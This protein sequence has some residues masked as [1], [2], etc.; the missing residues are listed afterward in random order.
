MKIQ[1]ED[2]IYLALGL[3]RHAMRNQHFSE[4]EQ[5]MVLVSASELTR[6]VL[7]HA[8][9]NGVFRCECIDGGVRLTVM[10]MGP[11]IPHVDDILSSV[12]AVASKRGLGLG[13]AGV[14]RLM[15]DMRIE[16]SAEGTTVIATKWERRSRG[17]HTEPIGRYRRNIS[18]DCS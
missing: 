10:D 3:V 17:L 4:I 11:G 15:D 12:Q 14:N 2:D 8:G 18:G 7:D 6:N 16:T 5:Q 9:R 1:S 13:L